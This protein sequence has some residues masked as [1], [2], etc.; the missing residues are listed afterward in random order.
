MNGYI[1][2]E[3]LKKELLARGFY[4]AIVKMALES[5]PPANVVEMPIKT[6]VDEAKEW[7]NSLL[8][9]E[10]DIITTKKEIAYWQSYGS[11]AHA[12]MCVRDLEDKLNNMTSKKLKAGKLIDQVTDYLGR[13]ILTRRYILCEKWDDIARQ[14]G[15]MT[16]RNA[17]IIYDKALIEFT[18]L[19]KEDGLKNE[20]LG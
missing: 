6:D 7:L 15:G 16:V 3:D 12:Y 11:D 1:K 17:R 20:A 19:W 2:K 9:C 14:L 10:A 8:K 4:P 13:A 5:M 18:R